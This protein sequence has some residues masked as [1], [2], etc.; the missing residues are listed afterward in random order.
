M[1]QR[2]L[3]Q[4]RYG[5]TF[6]FLR[7]LTSSRSKI[8]RAVRKLYRDYGL[9]NRPCVLCGGREF[10]LICEGDRYG[11]DLDKQI[12]DHCGLVQTSPA[13]KKDFLD[14][15]YRDHYR[16][17]YTKRNDVDHAR[18]VHE[19]RQKGERF[20]AYLE[21]TSVAASLKDLAV[22]EMGCSSGGILDEFRTRCRSVQGCD[23]DI[24]AIRYGKEQL[25]LD[26]EV[27]E[28]P[29][30][31]PDGPRL[32][33]LSH[34][35]EHT[36]DP[37]A[38]MKQIKTLMAAEDYL[39]IEVPGINMVAEGDY[40]HDLKSYFHLA[41]V[42][43][44]SEGTLRALAARAGYEVISCNET[45]TALLRPSSEAELPWQRSEKDTPENILRIDATRKG[46]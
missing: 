18:L 28:F 23:L 36:H 38:S 21:T 7:R 43:D 29:T 27:A 39:F 8:I 42:C 45:V 46:R 9:E 17:L 12:C 32:F 31:L 19:Q 44:F 1:A 11:F 37:L 5:R 13:V 41:H 24:E 30:H 26:L 4:F 22:I 2:L 10:T 14:V 40:K 3:R 6:A 33:I 34:V 35:L 16:R 15:F 25:E 20:L